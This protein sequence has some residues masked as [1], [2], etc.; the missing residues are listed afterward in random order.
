MLPLVVAAVLAASPPSASPRPAPR[1]HPKA[2]TTLYVPQLNK[3]D[4]LAAFLRAAG[5]KASLFRPEGWRPELH[6]LLWLDLTDPASLAELGVDPKG[7]ATWSVVGPAR[8]ICLTLADVKRH[9]EKLAAKLAPLGPK[10]TS[11]AK[12]GV[13]LTAA[14]QLDQPVAGYALKGKEVCAVHGGGTSID[15][16]LEDAAKLVAQPS[17]GGIWKKVATT[18]DAAYWVSPRGVVGARGS[19]KSLTADVRGRFPA[20]ALEGSGP[21]PYA[22]V[23]PSGL[24]LMRARVA[25]SGVSAVTSTLRGQLAALCPVCEPEALLAVTSD[26]TPLLTG[27][28]L[29]WADSVKVRESL[30]SPAARYFAVRHVYLAEV[31]QPEEAKKALAALSSWKNAKATGDGFLLTLKGGE[32]RVGLAGPHLY[33]GNDAATVSAALAAVNG[34][35]GKMPHGAELLVDPKA[36]AKGL[37]QISL[38]DVVGSQELAGLFAAG[39]ELGALLAHS[40]RIEAFADSQDDRSHRAVVTWTLP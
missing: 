20:P 1:A 6:P 33:L 17:T 27:N 11:K 3:A 9:Q 13:A 38:L 12:N 31:S 19:A 14:T 21:S 24:A 4:G 10:R 16:L 30:R 34:A 2:S 25:R 35:S 23:P 26:L 8:V 5:E 7:S 32:V 28:V 22:N 39:T 15:G 37:A 29:L 36:V 40:E 18:N